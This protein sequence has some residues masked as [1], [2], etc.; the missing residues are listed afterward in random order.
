M[1]ATTAAKRGA[2]GPS[3]TLRWEGLAGSRTELTGGPNSGLATK[4]PIPMAERSGTARRE[5]FPWRPQ[6][7][8]ARCDR[9]VAA[10]LARP[11]S[12]TLV[13]QQQQLR[14]RG[15]LDCPPENH[16]SCGA[17]QRI[18]LAGQKR[19]PAGQNSNYGHLN[20]LSVYVKPPVH[21]SSQNAW[22]PRV[23]SGLGQWPTNPNRRTQTLLRQEL[24]NRPPQPAA[25]RNPAYLAT[26]T[27]HPAGAPRLLF[28][29]AGRLAAY[30]GEK[31]SATLCQPPL[32]KEPPREQ[33]PIGCPH[34]GT[35]GQ[36]PGHPGAEQ[37]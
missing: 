5:A 25:A 22:I 26:R 34:P 30:S 37:P 13:G 27:P 23:R 31:H 20:Q 29:R 17:A 3:R 1:H 8:P 6:T 16:A 32:P 24:S 18:E 4:I 21:N 33:A 15:A 12:R 28:S 19:L 11:V 14:S 35:P 2:C 9:A 10:T 36:T 7:G